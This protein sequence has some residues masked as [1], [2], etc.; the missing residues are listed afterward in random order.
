MPKPIE[1]LKKEV[2]RKAIHTSG[3]AVP[4]AYL[5]ID[6]SL[7]LAGLSALVVGAVV[8]EWARLNGRI[9]LADLVR[10]EEGRGVAAYVYFAVASLTTVFLFPKMVAIAALLM[11]CIGDSLVGLLGVILLLFRRSG[12]TDVRTRRVGGS[13]IIQDIKESISAAKDAELMLSMLLICFLVGALFVPPS[14]AFVGAIGAM[15]ADAI[16]WQIGGRILDDDLTIPLFAGVLMAV[17][18]LF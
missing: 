2:M 6:R 13:G 4:V 16:P 1:I 15:L 9:K 17:V 18:S 10:L 7:M 14:V 5:F 12:R 3:I 11:L 8:I